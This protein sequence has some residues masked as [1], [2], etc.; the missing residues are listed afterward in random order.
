MVMMPDAIISIHA[1]PKFKAK[2][3]KDIQLYVITATPTAATVRGRPP[4]DL[5]VVL[6]GSSRPS[7]LQAPWSAV[8]LATKVWSTNGPRKALLYFCRVSLGLTGN[9]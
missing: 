5:A 7:I 1:Q 9:A 4:Y 2:M 6:S 3:V 8:K